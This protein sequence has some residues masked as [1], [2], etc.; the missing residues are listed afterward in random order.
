MKKYCEN[1]WL[2]ILYKTISTVDYQ[3]LA[4]V[5]VFTS[6]QSR[7][8]VGIL[9]VDDNIAETTESFS[10]HLTSSDALVIFNV[11]TASVFIT[12]NDS[13]NPINFYI[14]LARTGCLFTL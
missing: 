4:A 10:V 11:S 9:I 12:D 6:A 13:K 5:L 2:G 3:F 1:S 14:L 7:V 8:C